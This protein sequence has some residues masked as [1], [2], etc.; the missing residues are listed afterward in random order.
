VFAH[1]AEQG[2]LRPIQS[3]STL[4]ADYAK[5]GDNLTAEIHCSRD[6]RFVYVSNRGHDSIAVFAVAENGTLALV[7]IVPAGV[8]IPRGFGISPDGLW[9]IAA[10]QSSNDLA[11]HRIS[12]ETG[13]LS[14]VRNFGNVGAPVNVEFFP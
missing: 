3:L 9:L 4:P 5:P 6:G 1:D 13:K 10:G 2:T 11:L 12:K 14:F 7:E 8:K